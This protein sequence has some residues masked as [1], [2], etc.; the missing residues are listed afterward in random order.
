VGG[1]AVTHDA[2]G[3]LTSDGSRTFAYDVENRLTSVSGSVSMTLGY[4]PG[5]RLRAA[6]WSSNN[7]ILACDLK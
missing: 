3:N 1:A 5:G 6:P 2:R 4:D 7:R